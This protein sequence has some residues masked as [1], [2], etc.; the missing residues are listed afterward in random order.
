M[1]AS[2]YWERSGRLSSPGRAARRRLTGR[3]RWDQLHKTE[4]THAGTGSRWRGKQMLSWAVMGPRFVVLG[5][6]D[7][8]VVPGYPEARR[9]ATTGGRTNHEPRRGSAR[10][11]IVPAY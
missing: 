6:S 11:D 7:I 5:R 8:Q 9:C 2:P 1:G 3:C 10:L 4:K